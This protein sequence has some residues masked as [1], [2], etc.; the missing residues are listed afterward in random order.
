MLTTGFINEE[1]AYTELYSHYAY[2]NFGIRGDS[3]V[4]FEGPCQVERDKL[5]DLEDRMANTYIEAA[6]MLHFIVEHF[7][8]TLRDIVTRQRLLIMLAVEMIKR[9]AP[10]PEIIRKGDDL[11]VGSGKLSVSIATVSP[12]S[13]LIHLGMN[14]DGAGAPVE[15]AELPALGIKPR[16]FAPALMKA[17]ARELEEIGGAMC[18]VVPV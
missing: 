14:I 16:I 18:K 1:T 9:R 3:I 13:G 10:Q 12:V 4:S 17:Y 6:A 8:V 11:Y 5:V 7:G 2:R 15:V